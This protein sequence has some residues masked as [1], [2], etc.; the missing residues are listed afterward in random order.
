MNLA[1]VPRM[2]V[3]FTRAALHLIEAKLTTD[4]IYSPVFVSAA[5]NTQGMRFYEWKEASPVSG[6]RDKYVV[7]KYFLCND[8]RFEKNPHRP[9]SQPPEWLDRDAAV[10][11]IAAWDMRNFKH[12]EGRVGLAKIQPPEEKLATTQ[13][14]QRLKQTL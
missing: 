12:L 4:K 14:W 1:S 7:D 3:N 10:E 13:I 2:A 6:V 5:E 8:G 11:E 9:D